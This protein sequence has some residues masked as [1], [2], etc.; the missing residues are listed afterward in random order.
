[1]LVPAVFTLVWMTVFGDTALYL[2][3]EKGYQTLADSVSADYSMALFTFLEHFP[4]PSF[5]CF[6]AVLMV[7]LFFITSADSA[8]MV[9]DM[10]AS[11]GKTDTPM[12]QSLFWVAV[13]TIVTISLMY[14]GGLQALQTASILGALP[15]SVALLFA[16]WGLIK[17]LHL[18]ATRKELR[19]QS[20][21]ISRPTPR[22]IGGWQRRLRNLTMFTRRSHIVRFIE[23]V[24]KP[25]FDEVADE[26]SKQGCTATVLS[27]DERNRLRLELLYNDKVY[28]A[29]EVQ[30]RH[31]PMPDIVDRIVEEEDA[32]ENRSYF[33]ADVHLLEGGQ[34]YDIMGWTKDD[35]VSDILDQYETY[36]HF[37]HV[38]N[39]NS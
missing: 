34:D 24:V 30:P 11:N 13:I 16:V 2:I 14:S 18:D 4:L 17:A 26:F 33:R 8:S 19:K 31:Y 38:T 21:N 5:V 6:F 36:L 3:F 39:T 37:L 1:M 7:F 25:A 32:Q 20:L 28:F 9:I 22:A 35:V 23:E 12:W 27:D 10:F 29:Y 15:F